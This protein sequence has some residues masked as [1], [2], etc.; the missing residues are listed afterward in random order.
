MK[1]NDRLHILLQQYLDGNID[2]TEQEELFELI[3][4]ERNHQVLL[5]AI[6]N[7]LYDVADDDVNTNLPPQIAEEIIVKI[8]KT[9]PAVNNILNLNSKRSNVFNKIAIAA[10][11]LGLIILT[12]F[13]SN[14]YNDSKNNF[15]TI[16]PVHIENNINK[17]KGV[18]AILLSDGTQVFLEP[19]SKL[20]FDKQFKGNNR[21][22]Y[23][24]GEAFFKVKKNP[25]KPF[26]VYYN[27]IVT[28]VLGTSFRIGTNKK[29]GQLIV[30]V[31]TGRVQV[32]ENKKLTTSNI[33]ITPVI[34]TP[35]QKVTYD[36]AIRR[37]ETTIVSHPVQVLNIE[38]SIV[39]NPHDLLFEQQKLSTVFNQIEKFYKIE[40]TV[41]NT[42]IYNCI[43]TGDISQ[44]D[45]FSALKIITITTNAD[46][47][48]NGTK[49]LIK[50]KGC[51]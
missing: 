17:T 41:E 48:I 21:E 7:D 14:K 32:S 38:D 35:N 3:Q 42:A 5:N 36:K 19:G 25:N 10:S 1:T 46:Y 29:N 11:I 43:F 28:K 9:E 15:A 47:E 2:S 12:Y 18:Q 31:A 13:I 50:G 45:L 49:I 51:Q 34:I 44:L 23:L 39:L 22:V 24:E 30:E 8:F 37:F 6:E 16:I 26:L 20:Y 4:N 40:I 27:N 33:S